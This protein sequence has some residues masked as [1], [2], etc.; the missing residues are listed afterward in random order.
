MPDCDAKSTALSASLS[1]TAFS[2]RR[3]SRRS[4]CFSPAT[5]IPQI[6]CQ[7][8]YLR[9]GRKVGSSHPI[10]ADG[11]FRSPLGARTVTR[12][13]SGAGSVLFRRHRWG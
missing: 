9:D 8:I 1:V 2:G 13:R 10:K 3:G 4:Q 7:I 5:L 11:T 6:Y 12:R